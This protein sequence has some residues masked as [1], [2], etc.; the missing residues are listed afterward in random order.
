MRKDF[1]AT[2]AFKDNCDPQT[3]ESIKLQIFSPNE[4]EDMSFGEI[5]SPETV[6]YRT[7]G[8]VPD[9]LFCARVFGPTKDWQCECGK[10]KRLKH[11][12]VIC[13][14]CGVEVTLS[15]VRRERMGHIR[16]AT[17]VAHI[18][19]LKSLPS[20]ISWMLD[21]K[22]KD[23]ERVLYYEAY[24]VIDGGMTDLE[25]G[26]MLT[27]EEYYQQ[28]E[29]HG[30]E[31]SAKMGGEAI[32]EILST[33]DIDVEIAHI[34]EELPSITSDAKRKKQTK[35]LSMLNAFKTSGNRPQDMVMTVLPVLPP[36]L[37]PLVPLPG[38]RFATSDLNDLYR[39][40]INRNNRLKRLLEL[41]APS[42]I[43]NNEKRMLQE[44][45][46]ALFDNGRRGKVITG[47]NKRPLQSIAGF[48]KGKKGR[49]R[50]NLLGKRV[51]FSARSVIVVGPTLKLH[52]C[53]IPK[54]MAIELFK[55][56]VY[57]RLQRLG[58]ASTIKSAKKMVER[59]EA[60]VWDV[61]EHVIREHPVLLN[62]APTLH[63]LS[64]QAFEPK[65]I[66]GKAIQLH[67]LAC[68]SFNADFD[69]D[70]M[71]VHVP[72]TYEAQLEARCLMMST[73]NILS[74]ASGKPVVAPQLDIILGLY[75]LTQQRY[76][77]KGEGML[78]SN[79]KELIKAFEQEL[80]DIHALVKV[81]L[82]HAGETKIVETTP[83]RVT[84]KRVLPDSMPFGMINTVLKKKDISNLVNE[85]YRRCD[86]KQTVVFV[87]QIMYLGF[88]YATKSG[89]SI[90]IDNIE[91]P[92]QKQ[93]ILDRGE[94]SVEVIQKQFDSG[95]ITQKEF[96]NKVIDVW[97]DV[98][99]KV[100]DIM[101][102]DMSTDTYIDSDGKEQKQASANPVFMMA[103][104]GARGSVAQLRQLAGMRGPMSRPDGSII[105]KPVTSNLKE[106]LDVLQYYTT[107]HGSR[108][109]LADTALK[110]ANSGHLTRRLVDVAQDLVITEVDCQTES[111]IEISSHIEGGEIVESLVDR[112]LGR[113]LSSDVEG[114]DG[115]IIIKRGEM[116]DE[117]NV[118]LLD[119]HCVERVHVR[120][121]ITCDTKEGV[122]SLC[123]GRD[124]AR[125]RMVN[126]GEA[127]G[128]IAAQSIGE[129]GTQLTLRTFHIGGAASRASAE[130]NIQSRISGSV[131]LNNIKTLQSEEGRLIAISRSG[132]ISVIDSSGREVEK[133]PIA[134]GAKIMFSDGEEIIAG[135]VLAEWDPY[136]HSIISEVSGYIKLHDMVEGVTVSRQVDEMT[137]LSSIVVLPTD[138]KSSSQKRPMIAVVDNKGESVM[139][140]GS[141]MPATYFLGSGAVTNLEDG[142]R[143]RIGDTIAR[144]PKESF[145]TKDI[146]GG[147][148]RVADLFEARRPKDTAVYAELSGVASFG[149]ETKEKRR[150][151][152][153][154]QDGEMME[155]LIPR[156]RSI[157]VFE[158]E[159]V[160][161]GDII[162]DGPADP[163]AILR[164]LGVSTFANYI[165]N[166]VQDVYRLQ[167]VT[168]NDKHIEVIAKQMLRKALVLNP[169]DSEF[170]E[171][172]VVML[173]DIEEA[174]IQLRGKGVLPKYERVLL[175][176]TK[177]SL[178]TDSW[179][180]AASFQETTRILTDSA[181]LGK[182]DILRGLKENVIVGRLIPAG[183]GFNKQGKVKEDNVVNV[184]DIFTG[185]LLGGD[186]EEE[187]IDSINLAPEDSDQ[188]Q[189]GD[190]KE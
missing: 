110:T 133:Y 124:L 120:T 90:G 71:S 37:R 1:G 77:V 187:V 51:D 3:L 140:P 155:E 67:P 115:K 170:S 47:T 72:L 95:L 81:R 174:S 146:A 129:P 49:F 60:V 21:M 144:I 99:D 135:S 131:R 188:R 31:F 5:K 88:E 121:V 173:R 42:I 89:A 184:N 101:M 33:I 126:M 87:D 109:G 152:I 80:V 148:P 178:T 84:L 183:T 130:N 55:P 181:V 100:A 10:Y 164:L 11:R 180:S 85:C 190:E 175:G 78:F 86:T 61:L 112:V 83:G 168:I 91:I 141:N 13:E 56:F 43:V 54:K 46:D 93:S 18:W 154:S 68:A 52:Q 27:E 96:S 118:Q 182:S 151:I 160:E 159:T 163:H 74:P 39:R 123:Y 127:V 122:C 50:Q 165:V 26:Q 92:E 189:A 179:I 8:P 94:K 176:I 58:L 34:L 19:F 117:K 142:T 73:N 137:G 106:G 64:I 147:L 53:G 24:I 29:T 41:G 23:V 114:I 70:T 113:V 36:D 59:E 7:F 62:R 139:I 16:L 136:T 97:S 48:L 143:I 22:R 132:S 4:I 172:D 103:D 186:Q 145:K 28:L 128:I 156:W 169:G 111:G 63:R 44:S 75:Y 98:A 119:E 35:R 134:Y 25:R 2:S 104:S 161:K 157:T 40:V 105:E 9:G 158:G 125:G 153:T 65:L 76:G 66:E 102:K 57:G 166:E 79:E 30:D 167:G 177:A 185:S 15:K 138:Q 14:K 20:R 107:T 38:G 12:G 108:K 6:N 45:V 149:K 32:H 82:T 171:G 150:L 17:P 69:G 162:V 116:L